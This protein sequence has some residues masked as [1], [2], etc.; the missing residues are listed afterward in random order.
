MRVD[1]A[2]ELETGIAEERHVVLQ[3]PLLATNGKHPYVQGLMSARMRI[4]RNNRFDYERLGIGRS[5]GLQPF[6]GF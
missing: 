5:G 3:R 6:S 2:C 4:L 1:F